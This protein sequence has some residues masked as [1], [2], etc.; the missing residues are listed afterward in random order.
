MP[1]CGDT[2]FEFTEGKSDGD[3][4]F[5]YVLTVNDGLE[6]ITLFTSVMKVWNE[7]SFKLWLWFF[8]GD[9]RIELVD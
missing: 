6:W 4:G 2:A 5:I 7:S 3:G 9:I 1:G 8:D